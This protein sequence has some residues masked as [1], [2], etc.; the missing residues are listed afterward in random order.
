MRRAEHVRVGSRNGEEFTYTPR[1]GETTSVTRA[2]SE[3]IHKDQTS[4]LAVL[5]NEIRLLHF[6]EKRRRVR[7]HIVLDS[8]SCEDA[9]TESY[10]G[11]LGR[12]ET[13]C[14]C[15]D[16]GLKIEYCVVGTC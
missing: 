10:T 6:G 16:A 1:Q 4:C 3:L 9:I 13:T 14:M 8:D 5:K 15:H 11:R 12:N 7:F 2:S